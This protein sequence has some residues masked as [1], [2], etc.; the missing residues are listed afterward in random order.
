M[1]K[2]RISVIFA[3][4]LIIVVAGIL[5]GGIILKRY[6]Y[7]DEWVDMKEYLGQ[8]SDNDAAVFINDRMIEE[9]AKRFENTYYL[10]L[11][12]V[13]RYF[14]DRF[15]ANAE[16]GIL[17]F[18]SATDIIR[19]DI[20][21]GSNIQY[22]GE[23]ARELPYKAALYYN[24][25]LYIAVDYV[26]E[27]ADMEWSAYED[28]NR[29]KNKDK[30]SDNSFAPRLLIRTVWDEYTQ[31][32]LKKNTVIREKGGV[33]SAGVS[34]LFKG[35]KVILLEKMENWSRVMTEDALIGYVENK[36]LYNMETGKYMKGSSCTEYTYPN[37]K[38]EGIINLAFHQVFNQSGAEALAQALAGTKGINVI[39][40]T[41]FRLTDNAGNISS[42]SDHGYVS[43]AHELGIEVWGLVTDVDSRELYGIDIDFFELLK[44]SANRKNLINNLMSQVDEYGLDGVNIDFEKVKSNAGT[45]FV[46]FLRELSI[47]TRKRGVVLS[48]D[49]FVPT[50]YT[51]HYDRKEQ[52]IVCDYLII[53]GYDEHYVGG[54]EAGSVASIGYVEDGIV[55]TKE[56]VDSSKLINAI[57]FYTRVWESGSDGLK[58]QSLTMANQ[59]QWLKD[60]G[61]TPLWLDE[62]CQYYVEYENGGSLYQCWLEDAES[63]RVKLQVMKAQNIAGVASWKLGIEDKRV[64]DE[65][66]QYMQQ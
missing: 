12:T 50:E 55:K 56:V 15:Y 21:D 61:A 45:H 39:S 66:E 33:K 60:T 9:K 63:I 34:A 29:N 53:M 7:S 35:D 24:D 42:L 25:T 51:A 17:L 13:S 14:C 48:V 32:E 11:P 54:G 16:E 36:L 6:S 41:W 43:K 19:I 10:D 26:Q 59:A 49:N 46:Q 58:A 57:P 30:N 18:T 5:F 28:V 8:E 37:I 1:K 44:S 47:E 31:Y 27:F 40:P 2:E 38:K 22:I 4:A 65:I 52:G 23:S 62:C 20:G 3:I 64:W